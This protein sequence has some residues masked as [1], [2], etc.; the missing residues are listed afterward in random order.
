MPTPAQAQ[1]IASLGA[2]A[3]FVLITLFG[4]I[5]LWRRWLVLGWLYDQERSARVIAET[6]AER[7]ADALE[8]NTRALAETLREITAVRREMRVLRDEFRRQS[9]GVGRA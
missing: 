2:F 1:E 7:N 6:Q 4:A 5:A 3:L 9:S 8:A